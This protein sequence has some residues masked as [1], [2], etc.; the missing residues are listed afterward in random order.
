[1]R[2]DT[3][4]LLQQQGSQ[5][6]LAELIRI[7]LKW[8]PEMIKDIG[9]IIKPVQTG[10]PGTLTPEMM[11]AQL[12]NMTPGGGQGIPGQLD[13]MVGAATPTPTSEK[14]RV[15]GEAGMI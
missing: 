6:N 5:L 11:Q 13:K 15:G 7:Y 3:I 8:Y 4:A 2:T 12:A 14:E 1:M 10:Q 9:R